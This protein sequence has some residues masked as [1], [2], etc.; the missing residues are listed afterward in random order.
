MRTNSTE[1]LKLST[2]E[3]L[4]I[5]LFVSFKMFDFDPEPELDPI[6]HPDPN[7]EFP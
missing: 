2:S 7:L 3:R 6:L 4:W 1:V 5:V